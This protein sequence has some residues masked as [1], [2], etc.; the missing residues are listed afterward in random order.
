M[1]VTHVLVVF[2]ISVFGMR[3]S[4]PCCGFH[5]SS[6]PVQEVVSGSS[7]VNKVA[8]FTVFNYDLSAYCKID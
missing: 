3:L 1:E 2:L 7:I 6:V 8:D 4:L 5:K